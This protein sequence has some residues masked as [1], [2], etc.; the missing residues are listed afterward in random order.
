[1]TMAEVENELVDVLDDG[2]NVTGTATRAEV[3]ARNL[4]HRSVFVAVV[5]EAD[6]LLVHRRAD[7][8]DVWPGAWDVAFG[9]VVEAGEPW[10]LAASRELHEETGIKAE[11]SYLGEDVYRDDTVREWARI[12]LAR[13]D[14]PVD[15]NDGEVV[16]TAW[17]P[18]D[19]LRGWLEGRTLCP[20]SKVLVVPRLDAP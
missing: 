9:G 16:E 20:D 7:W 11:L 8:K 1:M 13:H 4:M 15:F 19:E 18:L 3:R 6:E 12:Y 10:E 2:G 14:G 17:V 5:N